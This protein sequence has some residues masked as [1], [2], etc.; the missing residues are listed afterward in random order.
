M[1]SD[2]STPQLLVYTVVLSWNLKNYNIISPDKH[3]PLEVFYNYF[4]WD[5]DNKQF[6][7]WLNIGTRIM[8]RRDPESKE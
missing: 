1:D 8:N 6:G 7:E 2:W 5:Y 3:I 4:V